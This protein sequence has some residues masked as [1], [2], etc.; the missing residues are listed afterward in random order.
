MAS[1]LQRRL[2]ELERQLAAR[3]GRA[4]VVVTTRC[5][6]CDQVVVLG[7]TTPCGQHAAVPSGPLTVEVVFVDPP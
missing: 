5:A 6:N 3:S 4:G 2:Y 7:D 1:S